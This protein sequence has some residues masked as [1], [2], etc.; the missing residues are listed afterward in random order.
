MAENPLPSICVRIRACSPGTGVPSRPRPLLR[1]HL[2]GSL[3][4]DQDPT[5]VNMTAGGDF[6][7]QRN[8][9]SSPSKISTILDANGLA[10]E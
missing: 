3:T 4:V 2:L 1:W 8:L 10:H 5:R 6:I 7:I 9:V